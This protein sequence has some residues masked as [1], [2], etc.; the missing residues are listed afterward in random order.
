MG[1]VEVKKRLAELLAEYFAPYRQ[2][3]AELEKDLDYVKN[4]L[5]D[6]AERARAAAAETLS[7]VRDAVGLGA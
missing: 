2:K 6:G 4:V 7:M 3:R 5:K 1:Y